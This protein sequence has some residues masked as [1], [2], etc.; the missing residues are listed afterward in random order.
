MLLDPASDMNNIADAIRKIQ[1]RA[2][3]IARA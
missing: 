2:A 3:E 1:A